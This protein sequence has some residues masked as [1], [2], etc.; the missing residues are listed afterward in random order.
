MTKAKVAI[1]EEFIESIN[2]VSDNSELRKGFLIESEKTF[3]RNRKLNF[4]LTTFLVL[5][6][7]K[8]SLNIEILEY[9]NSLKVPSPMRFTKTAFC[10]RRQQISSNWFKF[11][12]SHFSKLYY[13]TNKKYLKWKKYKL[14]AIDGSTAFLVKEEQT[15]KF[16]EGG[17]NQYGTYPLCRYMKMYDILNNV[18]LAVEMMPMKI[19]ERKC[20]YDWVDKIPEDSITL[21]DRGFPSYTLFYLMQ[22]CEIPKEFIVRCKAD[23]STAVKDF[24]ASADASKCIKFYPDYRA[25]KTLK[26]YKVNVKKNQ[27]IELRAEKIML[28]TGAIEVLLTSIK[29]KKILS[30]KEIKKL[31]NKRWGIETA[32]GTEK[33]IFQLEHFSS[34]LKNGIEQDFYATF[35]ANNIHSLIIEKAQQE[36]K[37]STKNR[38]HLYKINISASINCFKKNLLI[39]YYHK[40][41]KKIINEMISI[42]EMFVE[43]VRPDR[44][45]TRKR[46]SKR[47]YGKHQ[48]QKNYRNNL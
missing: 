14:L 11:L 18:T 38:Q 39:L 20:A 12:L 22:N 33:N 13:Q 36:V 17:L 9:F 42:F 10:L 35:I 21:F 45:Y 5:S 34:H 1:I 23:F 27:F 30:N 32:I 43:P 48:T 26:E 19:S 40:N 15:N 29:D 2:E 4:G 25:R 31:Y 37:T 44:K 24:V 8:K 46:L 6:L 7:L 3:T 28:D 41:K 16:Y 47:R